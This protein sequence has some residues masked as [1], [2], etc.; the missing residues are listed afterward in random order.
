MKSSD[1][2]D[3]VWKK[4]FQIQTMELAVVKSS[5]N[6]FYKSKYADLN[7]VNEVLIPVFNSLNLV[8]AVLPWPAGL[9]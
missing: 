8:I 2:T 1:Q 6:P 3:Q 9:E 4:I 7:T 5:K